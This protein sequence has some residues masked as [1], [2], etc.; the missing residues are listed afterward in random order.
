M[1]SNSIKAELF[2][3]GGVT[4]INVLQTFKIIVSSITNPPSTMPVSTFLVQVTDKQFTVLN[5]SPASLTVATNTP[6]TLSRFNL[7]QNTTGAG[8]YAKYTIKIY[9]NHTIN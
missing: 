4:Q 8:Q 2:L 5:K 9:P 7:T 1:L 3:K 6:Y